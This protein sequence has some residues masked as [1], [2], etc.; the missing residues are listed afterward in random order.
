MAGK[1]LRRPFRG[2][3]TGIGMVDQLGVLS[4]KGGYSL[5]LLGAAAPVLP[6]KLLLP[7]SKSTR[8]E[9]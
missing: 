1:L 4:A 7:C 2:R 6:K 5:Y 3:A 8:A 9:L